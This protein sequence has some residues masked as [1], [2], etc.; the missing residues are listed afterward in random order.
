M[1]DEPNPV[2]LELS[3]EEWRQV[4]AYYNAGRPGECELID[5]LL[6]VEAGRQRAEFYKYHHNDKTYCHECFALGRGDDHDRTASDWL[7]AVTKERIGG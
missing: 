6:H 3:E 1:S 4:R 5:L 7:E 2:R